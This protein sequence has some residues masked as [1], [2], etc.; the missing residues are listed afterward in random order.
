V[1]LKK[2]GNFWRAGSEYWAL[3]AATQALNARR[4]AVPA[5]S[6]QAVSGASPCWWNTSTLWQVSNY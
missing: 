2:P 1:N 4:R 6:R 3:P 5:N